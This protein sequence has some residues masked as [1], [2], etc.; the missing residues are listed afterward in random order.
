MLL[1]A[2]SFL[3]LQWMRNVLKMIRGYLSVIFVFIGVLKIF[4]GEQNGTKFRD[5]EKS[6]LTLDENVSSRQTSI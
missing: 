2:I 3:V 1:A 6:A 5:R 4:F